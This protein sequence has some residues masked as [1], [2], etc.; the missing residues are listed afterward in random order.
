MRSA[1]LLCVRRSMWF[2]LSVF[3]RVFMM[4]IQT[5]RYELVS[6]DLDVQ[7]VDRV[8]LNLIADLRALCETSV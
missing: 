6:V 1:S 4:C 2:S 3:C 8:R 5:E 7:V